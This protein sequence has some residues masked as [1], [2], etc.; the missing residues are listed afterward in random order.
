MGGKLTYWVKDGGNRLRALRLTV[1]SES[2]RPISGLA[3]LR[4][5]RLMRI[6]EEAHRQGGRLSYSDLSIIMLSSRATLKRDV[7]L[8]RQNGHHLHI[9]RAVAHQDGEGV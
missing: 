7:S 5:Q 2:D 1:L 8:L 6:V 4:R 9:G 3:G